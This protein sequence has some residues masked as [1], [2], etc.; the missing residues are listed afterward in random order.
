MTCYN[1]ESG[2]LFTE[3]VDTFLKIKQEA[4]G[5]PAWCTNED[6]KAKF[7]HEYE[8]DEGIMLDREKIELNP[9]LRAVA[10]LCLC[11]LWGKFGQRSN[12]KQTNVVKT[13]DE[14]LK[15]VTDPGKEI[16]DNLPVND[17]TLYVNWRF[18]EENVVSA[19]NTNVVIA[20]YTTAQARLVLYSYLEKLGNSI[21]YTDTD[22]TL[23]R[24]RKGQYQPTLGS[25]LGDMTDEL[26][27]YGEG[28]YIDTFISIAPKSYAYRGVTSEGN[29]FECCRVKGITLNY[30]N[31]LKINF[32]SIKELLESYFHDRNELKGTERTIDLNFRAIRRTPLHEVV[33]RDE[34][35]SCSVVLKKRWY[36][37][38]ELSLP[39]GYHLTDYEK[40]IL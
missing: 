29:T 34:T 27:G 4:S 30:E 8:R 26:V 20:A 22:S 25:L 2:G 33:T 15:L 31:S 23:F 32:E 36:V 37:S 12:L 28:S 39:F 9:G 7:L 17:E 24:H 40:L 14:L 3:Y 5:W 10:K 21:I 13:R 35:K 11:S 38:E 1:G 6:T 19:R 18:R 16:F